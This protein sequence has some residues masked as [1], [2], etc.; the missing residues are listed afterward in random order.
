MEASFPRSSGDK[1]KLV[2]KSLKGTKC[3]TIHYHMYSDTAADNIGTLNV[4]VKTLKSGLLTKLFTVSG[5][6]G[7]E[8]QRK[9]LDISMK[10]KKTKYEVYFFQM[11]FIVA[12]FSIALTQTFVCADQSFINIFSSKYS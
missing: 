7:N 9:S 12:L 11:L 3:M 8:W 1:A 4:Y 10:N 2:S 6:Q 5:S